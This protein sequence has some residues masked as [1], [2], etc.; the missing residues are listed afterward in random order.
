MRPE[1]MSPKG[2]FIIGDFTPDRLGASYRRG[3]EAIGQGVDGYDMAQA[4]RMLAWPGRD[5]ILQRLT[6]R[7]L[8]ARRLWSRRLNAGILAS[9]KSSPSQTVLMLNGDWIM[10][11]TIHSLKRLGKRVAIFHAD[12]PFPPHYNN[13]PETL[14]SAREADLYLSWSERLVDNLHA[15]G[16]GAA[17][18][19]PFAWDPEVFPHQARTPQGTWPGVLFIGGWDREREEFLD[20]VAAH[21]PLRIYGPAYWGS[22]TRTKSR[23]RASWM[24]GP[25]LMSAAAHAIRDSAVSLNVLRTQHVVDGK[26][27]GV[28]MRHFEV[29]G[30]G[31]FLLSTRSGGA[32][33][34]FPE[35]ETAAY[36]SG[37]H[38]CVESCKMFLVAED[39]RRRVVERSHAEVAAHHT[40]TRRAADIIALVAELG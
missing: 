35:G 1:R 3:F 22:R 17:A 10:P 6:R 14:A 19:L 5:R 29:P 12:N 2:V 36:F 8:Q 13:R 34:L 24:G 27:D 37:V 20:E 4:L 7:S 11:E 33:R 26:P 23:A 25:L 38:E 21:V 31:G 40:Y 9:A 16:V 18:F 32:T 30:A 28:I 39:A 15:A